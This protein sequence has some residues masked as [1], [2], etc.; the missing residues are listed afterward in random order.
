MLVVSSQS[1]NYLPS[2]AV[3]QNSLKSFEDVVHKNYKL[4]TKASAGTL[5]QILAKEVFLVRRL[6][7]SAVL[8]VHM[9]VLAC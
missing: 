4:C 5:C 6:W 7:N 3:T 8:M 9:T 2:S 1:G